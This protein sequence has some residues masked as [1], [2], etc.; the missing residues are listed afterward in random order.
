LSSVRRAR[1][2][3]PG[4][5]AFAGVAAGAL[6]AAFGAVAAAL[7]ASSATLRLGPGAGAF[8]GVAAGA[9]AAA[10]GAEAAAWRASSASLRLG[11]LHYSGPL[12]LY[13]HPGGCF[14]VRAA[15][16]ISAMMWI[17]NH[18][19]QKSSISDPEHL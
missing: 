15:H 12:H 4:A 9:L 13:M 18:L 14:T 1:R 6:A 8:A 3:G 2:L 19:P 5:G 11:A 7:T 16:D 17:A 10:F